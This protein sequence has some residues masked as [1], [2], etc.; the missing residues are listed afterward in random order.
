MRLCNFAEWVLY[1]SKNRKECERCPIH[2][3]WIRS[4]GR[5][6]LSNVLQDIEKI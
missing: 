3:A 2:Q 5:A 4:R 6:I 1:C